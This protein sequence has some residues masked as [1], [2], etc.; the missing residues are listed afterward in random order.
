MALSARAIDMRALGHDD[1]GRA[2]IEA[3]NMRLE[4]RLGHG[5]YEEL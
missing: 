3:A 4:T 2:S 5:R 1:K